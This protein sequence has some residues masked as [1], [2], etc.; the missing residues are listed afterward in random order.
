MRKWLNITAKES[1]YSADSDDDDEDDS[2]TDQFDTEGQK[3]LLRILRSTFDIVHNFFCFKVVVLF[4]IVSQ[5]LPH[6]IS[7]LRREDT[8]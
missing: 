8:V 6:V 4:Y 2:D 3:Y 5:Y 7:L 1:D